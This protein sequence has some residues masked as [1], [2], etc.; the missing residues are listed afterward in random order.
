MSDRD[1]RVAS[2]PTTTTAWYAG[3]DYDARREQAG[4][5]EPG[6]DLTTAATRRDG[7]AMNWTS[8]GIAPPPN[9][10]TQLVA[11]D[12]EVMREMQTFVPTKVTNPAPGT[13]VFDFG[14]NFAG[15]PELDLA[16][17]PAGTT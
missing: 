3:E 5:N 4:W 17:V 8:A 9:L 10:A 12:G 16:Q 11:R 2:G 14:Q 15:W 7:S 13:W 6:A 1:W